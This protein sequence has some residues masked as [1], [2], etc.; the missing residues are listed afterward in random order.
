MGRAGAPR[1]ALVHTTPFLC[2]INNALLLLAPG[3][4]SADSLRS[5]VSWVTPPPQR[6]QLPPLPA[7]PHP[8]RVLLDHWGLELRRERGFLRSLGFHSSQ[9]FLIACFTHPQSYPCSCHFPLPAVAA[10]QNRF[11]ALL[12]KFSGFFLHEVS[13]DLGRIIANV[14]NGEPQPAL[15]CP[16]Q[17][18]LR[19]GAGQP[20]H[21][22]G[23]VPSAIL[24]PHCSPPSLC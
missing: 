22:A 24:G 20:V 21:G 3:A 18:A 16:W 9:G 23:P 13:I 15:P 8:T 7:P 1:E 19:N 14:K 12:W 11:A 17:Q 5:L 10:T 2:Y 4:H 6:G